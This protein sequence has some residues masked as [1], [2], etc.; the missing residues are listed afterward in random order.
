MEIADLHG[1]GLTTAPSQVDGGH[2]GVEQAIR[3]TR[4][5]DRGSMYGG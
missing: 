1:I 3:L 5:G 2:L 4:L